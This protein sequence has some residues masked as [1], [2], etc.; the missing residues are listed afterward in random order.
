MSDA[1]HLMEC[2]NA[3]RS[4]R[5]KHEVDVTLLFEYIWF[6]ETSLKGVLD[7]EQTQLRPDFV[8]DKDSKNSK[9]YKQKLFRVGGTLSNNY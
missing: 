5:H 2:V 8:T 3:F 7:M 4:Y 9:L 1:K 6:R